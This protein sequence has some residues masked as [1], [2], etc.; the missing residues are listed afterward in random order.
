MNGST[1]PQAPVQ[2]SASA[3][4]AVRALADSSPERRRVRGRTRSLVQGALLALLCLV[5]TA[6]AVPAS[7]KTSVEGSQAP[8]S[9]SVSAQ[10]SDSFQLRF[11]N[12]YHQTVSVAI[13]YR[14]YSGACD[15]YGGWATK[16]WWNIEPGGE[17]YVLNTKNRHV[18]FY[19]R[20]PDSQVQW[21]GPDHHMYASNRAF[22]SCRDIGT[23]TWKYVGLRHINMGSTY[24][25]YTY[26]LY[27]NN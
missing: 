25:N 18:Y 7:A 11:H 3:A 10:S 27:V 2:T 21:T 12:Y 22:N 9:K 1:S 19:A 20:T 4:V 17:R 5:M 16:G 13:M 6:L 8:L 23:S 26:P 24:A 15:N 14:D